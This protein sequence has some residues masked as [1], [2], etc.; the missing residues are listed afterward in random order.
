MQACELI[1]VDSSKGEDLRAA[2]NKWLLSEHDVP[3]KV[4]SLAISY[5]GKFKEA[6]IIY[7]VISK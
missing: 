2:I 5:N 3:V 4:I 6:Y 7:E 1:T